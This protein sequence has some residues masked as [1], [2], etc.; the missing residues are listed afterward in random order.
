MNLQFNRLAIVILLICSLTLYKTNA[1]PKRDLDQPALQLPIGLTP[2]LPNRFSF[3]LYAIGYQN[4]QCNVSS[5]PGDTGNWLYVSPTA[6]LLNGSFEGRE[7]GKHYF[8]PAPGLN[9][10]R[11]TWHG[12]LTTDMSSVVTKIINQKPSPDGPQNI[13]WLLTQATFNRGNG[14]FSDITYVVR[15]D[16][17]NGIAPPNNLCGTDIPN[18]GNLENFYSSQYWFYNNPSKSLY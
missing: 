17:K 9:G 12:I 5:I 15:V 11:A 16:T 10:G 6:S 1:L 18:E 4:Y 8:Q 7:I 3:V 14:I 2:P 13:D